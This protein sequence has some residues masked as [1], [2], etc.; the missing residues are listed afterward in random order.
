[1]PKRTYQLRQSVKHRENTGATKAKL[2]I[3]ERKNRNELLRHHWQ[4]KQIKQQKK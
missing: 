1:M 2:M 3:E 4:M